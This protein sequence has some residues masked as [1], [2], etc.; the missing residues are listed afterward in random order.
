MI[1]K[2]LRA[3]LKHQS[4]IEFH[5]EN[6]VAGD[7]CGFFTRSAC[8]QRQSVLGNPIEMDIVSGTRAFA[9]ATATLAASDALGGG[10]RQ[11]A[12]RRRLLA[13]DGGEASSR[14]GARAKLRARFVCA[15]AALGSFKA[16]G[17]SF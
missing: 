10:K 14:R 11:S 8:L 7:F 4:V 5:A 2:L 1:A 3:T 16:G 6:Q 12:S 13:V 17:S 9:L 15:R